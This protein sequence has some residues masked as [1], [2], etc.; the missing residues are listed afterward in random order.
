MVP[1]RWQKHDFYI[2]NVGMGITLGIALL[3]A[4]LTSLLGLGRP[5]ILVVGIV[6]VVGMM[7]SITIGN[8]YARSMVRI[9]KFEYEE[10]ERDFRILFKDNHIQFHRK[11]EEDV[12]RY[13][14]LGHRLSMT[15]EPYQILNPVEEGQTTWFLAATQVTL[16]ELNTKNQAFAEK[17]ADLIDE[18]AE[19]LANKRNQA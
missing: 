8:R 13:N 12:Y 17:L 19:Q 2:R 5:G 7:V 16:S 14:F 10:I 3:L 9:L 4:F 1:S 11:T 15:I 18:M 6:A